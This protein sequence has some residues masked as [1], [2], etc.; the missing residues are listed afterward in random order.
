MTSNPVPYPAL[1]QGRDERNEK[2]R[3]VI[4]RKREKIGGEISGRTGCAVGNK[5][6][7]GV[8]VLR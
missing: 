7:H 5:G 8:R 4:A 6:G 3:M 1:G 2:R